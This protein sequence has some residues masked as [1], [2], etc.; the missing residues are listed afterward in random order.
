MPTNYD[1]D[2]HVICTY[3]LIKT[4]TKYICYIQS[5]CNVILAVVLY[6]KTSR[7]ELIHIRCF[8][9]GQI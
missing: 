4:E 3:S 6:M 7:A 5:N 9:V 2:M 1:M 8:H